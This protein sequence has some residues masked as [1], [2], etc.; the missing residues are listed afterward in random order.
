S[1]K[2]VAV[3]GGIYMPDPPMLAAIR[4]HIAEHHQDLRK[5]LRAKAV[6]S[7]LGDLHGEQAT[8]VPKGFACDHPAAD[9]LRFK[10]FVLYTTLPVELAA[11][12]ELYEE[13]VKRFRAMTPFLNFLGAATA[14]KDTARPLFTER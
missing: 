9:L 10:R 14:K 3:G 13:I 11:S 12:P 8:R 1:D 6:R 5:I 2:E 7:L 4:R